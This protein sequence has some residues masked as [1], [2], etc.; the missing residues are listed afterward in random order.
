MDTRT[1]KIYFDTESA[2]EILRSYSENAIGELKEINPADMTQKQA[3]TLQVSKHDSRSVLGQMFAGCRAERRKAMKEA[4]R[5]QKR[6]DKRK[7]KVVK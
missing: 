1:G 5:E 4:R 2:S 3:D 7:L 6:L